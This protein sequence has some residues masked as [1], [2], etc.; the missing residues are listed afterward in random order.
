MFT[1]TYPDYGK[2]YI[3]LDVTDKNANM[4]TK[5]RALTLTTGEKTTEIHV[6]SIPQ[7]SVSSTQ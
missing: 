6:L 3:S 1:T 4:A 2:Y 5:K 7:S